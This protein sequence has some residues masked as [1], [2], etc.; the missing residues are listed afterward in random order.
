[1]PKVTGYAPKLLGENDRPS[2]I[3]LNL[4][5]TVLEGQGKFNDAESLAREALPETQGCVGETIPAWPSP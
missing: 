2:A 1:L 3:S 5:A 4:L